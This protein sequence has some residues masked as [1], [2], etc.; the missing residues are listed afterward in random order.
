MSRRPDRRPFGPGPYLLAAQIKPERAPIPRGYPFVPAVHDL[1]HF[2]ARTAVTMIAGENGS[3]KS[4]LIEA[5]AIAAG[6]AT[7]GGTLSGEIGGGV[8]PADRALADAIEIETGPHR[9]RAGFFLRAES[10][11]NVAAMIDAKDLGEIYGGRALH[12]QSH[13]ESFLA[14]AANRF[15]ADGLFI[16]DEPEAALSVTSQLAFIALVQRAVALGSQFILA[17][18]SPIL[19]SYPG[20]TVYETSETGLALVQADDTEPVRLTRSFLAAPERFLR[21]LADDDPA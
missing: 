17:T 6:F 13:G 4:T 18:H 20:A 1:A 3:G 14:L 5:L 9:P 21:H 2:R 7:Q 19:L 10:F 8:V 15:G 16:F 12:A 11:F